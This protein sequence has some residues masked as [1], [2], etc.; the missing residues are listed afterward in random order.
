KLLR[1][2]SLNELDTT[3]AIVLDQTE[4]KIAVICR[5]DELIKNF[6]RLMEVKAVS[7]L[8]SIRLVYEILNEVENRRDVV[9]LDRVIKLLLDPHR[10]MC[11]HI[12]DLRLTQMEIL[13]YLTRLIVV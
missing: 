10:R 5:I 11:L 3:S 4:K 12:N 6:R 7:T 1:H 2:D 9:R 8:T 13:D